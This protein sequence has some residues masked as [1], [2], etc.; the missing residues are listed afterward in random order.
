MTLASSPSGDAGSA[1]PTRPKWLDDIAATLAVHSHFLLWGGVRDLHLVPQPTG[2]IGPAETTDALTAALFG[3]GLPV[4]IMHDPVLGV[5]ATGDAEV[6]RALS[7]ELGLVLDSAE[8]V[9]VTPARLGQL[10]R[11]L[12]TRCNQRA[13]LVVPYAA[14]LCVDPSRLDATEHEFFSA[15]EQSSRSS[16]RRAVPSGLSRHNPVIWLVTREQDFPHWV[17]ADN[18]QFRTVVV[19]QPDLGQRTAMA[20]FAL[21]LAGYAASASAE[22]LA[23]ARDVVA[24]ATES[25]S[26]RAVRDCTSLGRDLEIGVDDL[27]AAVRAYRVGVA[28]N[29]WRRSFLRQRISDGEREVGERVLGQEPAITAAFDILKRSVM[30]LA[31]AHARS[32][33]GRPRGILFF[34]GPTGVGKTELA[35]AL[36]GLVFGDDSAY[37]RFDMSEYSAEQAEARLIGAPPGYVGHDAGGQL[38]NSVRRKPFSLVL[39]DEIEKAHP[40]ILDKF[41]QILEDGRLT[42]SRGGT[43][44]FS[45]TLIVFTSN[46]GVYHTDDQGN[47]HAIVDEDTPYEEMAARLRTSISEHFT[48]GIGRP[49]LLNR[50]GENIVVFSFITRE[51]AGRIFDMQL[52]NVVE[53]IAAEHG[54]RLTVPEEIAT[55]IRNRCIEDRSLGGRGI[56]NQVEAMLVNPLARALFTLQGATPPDLAVTGWSVDGGVASVELS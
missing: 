54:T 48:L 44:H 37:L 24:A 9:P 8:A 40:R 26:L 47:R 31:G 46:L 17:I 36:T 21:G 39:F 7:E 19:P 1:S 13:A 20:E 3:T 6:R 41:L 42:D 51:V 11:D 22:E 18:D 14:R 32:S 49:E 35:K 33:A 5:W 12:Q 4:V 45:E 28:D 34:A 50:I 30:G 56:G 55:A 16:R 29:P 52:S 43:V 38:T 10:I 27:E 53:R 25:M 15:V 23:S 2:G